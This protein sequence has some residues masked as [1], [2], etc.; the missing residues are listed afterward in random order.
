MSGN[1]N[2]NSWLFDQN[3]NRKL[4]KSPLDPLGKVKRRLLMQKLDGQITAT[5]LQEKLK[6]LRASDD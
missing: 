4:A 1:Q 3:P 5:E 2:M 6:E